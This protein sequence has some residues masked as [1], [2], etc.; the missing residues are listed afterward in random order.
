MK[1][2]N[3]LGLNLARA[4][5]AFTVNSFWECS[6]ARECLWGRLREGLPYRGNTAGLK[7]QQ[8]DDSFSVLCVKYYVSAQIPTIIH[9]A[10]NLSKTTINHLSPNKKIMRSSHP[11]ANIGSSD[12]TSS[13]SSLS[14]SSY[15]I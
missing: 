7:A 4:E 11:M 14:S 9:R 15:L 10:Y 2:G 13:L 5:V 12:S 8:A 1:L 3:R 6:L